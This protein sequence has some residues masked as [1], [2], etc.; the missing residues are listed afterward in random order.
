MG[1]I[2]FSLIY[3]TLAVASESITTGNDESISCTNVEGM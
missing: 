1:L 2:K 3:E